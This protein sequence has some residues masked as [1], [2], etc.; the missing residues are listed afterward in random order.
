MLAKLKDGDLQKLEVAANQPRASALEDWLQRITLRAGGFHRLM[1]GF[2]RMAIDVAYEAYDQ[3]CRMQPIDR[4]TIQPR[5]HWHETTQQQDIEFKLRSILIECVPEPVRTAALAT[6]ATSVVEV[7]F[8]TLV[9][10][11]PGTLRDKKAVLE[12]VERRGKG[13]VPPDH[14]HAALQRWMF[15]LVRLQRLQM[16]PPDPVVQIG[17]LRTMVGSMVEASR[18]F[19][20]RL[21][22]F[23]AMNG[24]SGAAIATQQQVE[25]YWRYLAAESRELV[26]GGGRDRAEQRQAA[27]VKA[28][29]ARL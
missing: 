27:G 15:D 23:E 12:A 4:P 3:Y 26:D 7:L 29:I 10:G 11:G 25:K 17:V 9:W 22:S 14:V 28:H 1:D 19:E 2:I 18:T 21:N 20:F 13:A 5:L 6:R 8:G 24:L 16:S